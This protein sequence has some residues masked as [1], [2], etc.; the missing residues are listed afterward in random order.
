MRHLLRDLVSTRNGIDPFNRQYRRAELA[1]VRIETTAN[2]KQ[3][4][5]TSSGIRKGGENKNILCG[6]RWTGLIA[7]LLSPICS[8]EAIGCVVGFLATYSQPQPALP[9][10]VPFDA[11]I[12]AHRR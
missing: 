1:I 8:T 7:P 12:A 9:V 10:Q 11:A 4:D 6:R 2:K 3:L 5:R